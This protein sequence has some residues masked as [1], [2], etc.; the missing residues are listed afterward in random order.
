MQNRT[1]PSRDQR[2]PLPDFTPVPRKY[3][4]DGWTPD[5]QRALIE[6]LAETG[7]VR[8]AAKRINMAPEGAYQ[9]RLAAG[10]EGFRQA[11][12]AAL[13]LGVQRLVDIAIDRATDGVAVPVFYKGDQ[14]G[15]RRWYNDRLLMFL[16]KHHMPS[17]YGADLRGGT[18]HPDTLARE[19]E[20]EMEEKDAQNELIQ[21]RFAL[22]RQHLLRDVERDPD[23]R[24]AWEVL[25]GPVDWDR[26]RTAPMGEDFDNPCLFTDRS[27]AILFAAI[28][29]AL[30]VEEELPRWR[31]GLFDKEESEDGEGDE[32][33]DQEE[34]A[35]PAE[36]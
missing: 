28:D 6:A 11:W 21:R 26:I 7:S 15:E 2:P 27:T 4:H 35:A 9:L 33:R 22:L 8:H 24:A 12:Q 3:R 5:R 17:K 36:D 16:L 34:E 30:V 10:S 23:K 13:D 14:V 19:Y 25:C 31:E 32:E 20:E 1:L 18:K 29:G